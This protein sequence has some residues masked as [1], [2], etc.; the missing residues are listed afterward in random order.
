L[1]E[2]KNDFSSD[3][4]SKDLQA[5]TK[6]DVNCELCYRSDMN[7][8]QP[9]IQSPPEQDTNQKTEKNKRRKRQ[10]KWVEATLL[11]ALKL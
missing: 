1:I 4:T 3:Q 11:V 2:L 6:F 5:S 7:V 9:Q 10:P 8:A